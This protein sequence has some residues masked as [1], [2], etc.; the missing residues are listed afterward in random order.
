MPRALGLG[1]DR[2]QANLKVLQIVREATGRRRSKTSSFLIPQSWQ[3][4]D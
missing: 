2:W 3:H 1:S 4:P